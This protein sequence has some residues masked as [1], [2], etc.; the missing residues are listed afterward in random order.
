MNLQD[1]PFNSIA[2]GQ[3]SVELRLYDDKR[4]KILVGDNIEFTKASDDTQK[5]LCKVVDLKVFQNF[6]Q[7]FFTIRNSN[8]FM[9]KSGTGKAGFK[10]LTGRLGNGGTDAALHRYGLVKADFG[11]GPLRPMQRGTGIGHGA[12]ADVQAAIPLLA[13]NLAFAGGTHLLVLGQGADVV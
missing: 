10:A 3:K 9:I 5:I 6:Q 7:L 8:C 11:K 13:V 2:C 12:G 4:K 1:D